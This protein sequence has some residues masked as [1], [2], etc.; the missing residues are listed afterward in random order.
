MTLPM[1]SETN[2]LQSKSFQLGVL[3]NYEPF[4]MHCDSPAQ[5]LVAGMMTGSGTFSP[6]L[7]LLDKQTSA[8][9]NLTLLEQQKRLGR[10]VF[11]YF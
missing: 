7:R 11:A 2:A 10:G 5:G 4:A 8:L 3:H 1:R 9:H 6:A